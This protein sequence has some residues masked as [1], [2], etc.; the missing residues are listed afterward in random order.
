MNVGIESL[1]AYVT[2]ACVDIRE[3]FIERQLNLERFPN[4]MMVEKSV[5]LP[6][7]DPVTNAVNAAKPIIDKLTP[8]ERDSIEMLITSSESGLDFGKSL[9]TYIH[10]YL[11]LSKHCRLFEI[12]QACYAGTAALQMASSYVAANVSPGAKVLVVSADV[13]RDASHITYAEPSQGVASIAMLVSAKPEIFS[14]DL[15]A[16]GLFGHEIMDG[17]RPLPEIETGD[18][19]LSLMNYMHCL[20]NAFKHYTT[21]RVGVDF[22]TSFDYL[23]FHTPFAGLVKASHKKLMRELKQ[24]S[25]EEIEADFIQRIEPSLSYCRHVGNIYSG[26]LYLALTGIIDTAQ[27][28]NNKNIGLFSY[29]SGCSSEFYSGTIT[30]QS[31]QKLAAMKIKEALETRAKLPIATYD[32]ILKLNAEWVFGVKDKKV[33]FTQFA[34]IYNTHFSGRKLLTLTGVN[35][36]HREYQWS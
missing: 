8:Q 13:S 22:Q 9:S 36:F 2:R 25:P 21:R 31:K 18:P 17:C 16:S 11:G 3:L 24:A 1:N 32:R 20:E 30:P 28:E 19:D 15:G 14:L 29:G 7:E 10:D 6:W 27:Y 33:D 26:T 5:N 35:N 23:A 34:D 4:L 12:K